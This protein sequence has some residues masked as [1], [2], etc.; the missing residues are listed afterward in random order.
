MPYP[1]LDAT[2][3]RCWRGGRVQSSTVTTTIGIGFDGA[4]RMLVVA[5]VDTET[6]AG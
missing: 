3:V 1:F 5:A 6:H 4:R 2:Y